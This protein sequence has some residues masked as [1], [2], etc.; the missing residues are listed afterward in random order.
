MTAVQDVKSRAD[1]VEIISEYVAL[2]KAGRNFKANCPFHTEKTP[3]FIVFPERQSWRCFGACATGGDII[4]FVMKAENQDFTQ[5]LAHLAQRTGVTLPSRQASGKQETLH[6]VNEE[7]VDFFR[8]VL[9]S[10]EG[11]KAREYLQ[12]RG[13]NQEAEEVF[14]LGLSPGGREALTRHLLG[15]GYQQEDIL[16][17]GLAIKGE[18]GDVRDLFHQR[19]IFPIRDAS[20]R[21]AGFGGRALDDSTPKYLNTPR[22]PIFDKGSI[23]Y[24]LPQAKEAIGRAG[25]AVI[26]EGYMDAIAAH[27]YGFQN[28][29]ASMGTALTEQQVSRLK[30]LAS[31]FVLALDPDNA[32][33][34]ATLRSLESSWQATQIDF[35]RA[36]R[37]VFNQRH[38]SASSLKI[39]ALPAGK[40]PDVLIHEDAR[41]WERLVSEAPLLL[42]YLFEALPPRFDLN[43]DDGKRQMVD[44]LAP[45]IRGEGNPFTQRRYIRRLAGIVAFSETDLETYMWRAQRR[46]TASRRR[47][48]PPA[49]ATARGDPLEEYCLSLLLQHPELREKGLE[50]SPDYF[51]LS[52]NRSVFTKWAA[53]SIIES[54]G[55]SLPIDLTEHLQALLNLDDPPLDIKERERALQEVV[56]RL[57]ERFFKLQE[58]ALLEQMEGSDWKDIFALEPSLSQAQ[59]INQQLKELF[60]SPNSTTT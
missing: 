40:D 45:F 36:G 20:G 2:Q 31:T 25:L 19:L 54:I 18:R 14:Q 47:A 51:E 23:L 28:V 49:V 16:S 46:T 22:T 4:A 56:N 26:V 50:I 6:R 35:L 43:S 12:K 7:A 53:C 27:Q 44:S 1:I 17:A 38:M 15:R 8:K 33:K 30:S 32:G 9:H 55:D 34:E 13:V 52:E 21:V 41:E 60:S 11:S 39:V 58:Q 48:T 42:D 3:S 59:K 24:A 57:K 10:P 5:A 37:E 29:V